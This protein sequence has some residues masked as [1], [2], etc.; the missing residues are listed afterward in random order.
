ME[1]FDY[2][3]PGF[4]YTYQRFREEI[5]IPVVVNGDENRM[6]RL[7]HDPAIYPAPSEGEVL[8]DLPAKLEENVFAKLEGEQL[9]LYDASCAAHEREPGG[10]NPRRNSAP[11]RFRFWRS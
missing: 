1:Y 2:L 10:A 5:E 9:A 11:I 4:L 7:Q 3:M 6:Q 8:R